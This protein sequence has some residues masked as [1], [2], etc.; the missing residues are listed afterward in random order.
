MKNVWYGLGRFEGFDIP[1]P[2]VTAA[3]VYPDANSVIPAII[4][5]V[6]SKELLR[7]SKTW[8]QETFGTVAMA[9]LGSVLAFDDLKHQSPRRTLTVEEFNAIYRQGQDRTKIS[10]YRQK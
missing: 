9:L 5:K 1:G 2:G 6:N 7:D 3:Y 8:D 10:F 4:S